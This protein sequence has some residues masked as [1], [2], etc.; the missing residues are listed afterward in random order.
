MAYHTILHLIVI[1]STLHLGYL[2]GN[3][4]RRNK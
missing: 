2:I 4:A 3:H 1:A